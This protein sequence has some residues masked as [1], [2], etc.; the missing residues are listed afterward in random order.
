MNFSEFYKVTKNQ[1]D[2]GIVHCYIDEWYNAEFTSKKDENLN[3][4]EIGLDKGYSMILWRDWFTNSS[5]YGIEKNI[6]YLEYL[7]KIENINVKIDNAYSDEVIAEYQDDFFDY[8]IDD[9]PHTVES[10]LDCV[11]KWFSKLKKGGKIIIEDVMDI[12]N[13]KYLF[14]ELNIPYEL[15][16]LRNKSPHKQLNDVL[17]IFEK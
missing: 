2:K 13:S 10:Q 14:D 7:Q 16:D 5:I 15:I 8:I 17:L 3:I 6:Q 4:L 1:C 12:D 11:K 9:G